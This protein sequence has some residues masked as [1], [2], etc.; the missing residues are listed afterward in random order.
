MLNSPL[1]AFNPVGISSST[2]NL[3]DGMEANNT[4]LAQLASDPAGTGVTASFAT[5]SGEAVWQAP[6]LA[7]Y[8]TTSNGVAGFV[9]DPSKPWYNDYDDFRYDIKTMAKGYAVVPEFRISEQI[10]KY[11][12]VGIDGEVFDYLEIP[13]TNLSSSQNTFYKDY[14]NSDFMQNFLDIKSMSGLKATEIKLTCKAAIK[15]N[16]YKGFYPAQRTLNIVSQF[17]KSYGDSINI[18]NRS[19]EPITTAGRVNLVEAR[20]LIQPLFAPG[21]M[22]NSIKSGIAV[23]YPIITNGYKVH[24]QL[25][26]GAAD[27]SGD[28]PE[29]YMIASTFSSSAGTRAGGA[30]YVSGAFWDLRVPFEAIMNPTKYLNGLEIP[31]IEPHPSASAGVSVAR[32]ITASINAQNAGEEYSRMSSNFFAEVGKFFLQGGDYTKLRSTGVNLGKKRFTGEE[33]YGAR[34]RMR[35]SYTGPRTYDAEQGSDGTNYFYATNG[36]Q[37]FFK[38]FTSASSPAASAVTGIS[39]SFELPQDPER[40]VDFKHSFVMYSRPHSIWGQQS[41][42]V[43]M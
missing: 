25:V 9:S 33:V 20:P 18:L 27:A 28:Y 26:T 31:N 17:S 42:V 23:D 29:N 2:N 16:P 32:T 7:G 41:L 35:T 6:A 19:G 14:S 13:G 11:G 43:K 5:G 40:A 37:A 15:F 22:Y 12:K 30:D 10:E 24:R 36:A 38:N 34:L 1:S 3:V 4:H 21:I 39:G 8:I